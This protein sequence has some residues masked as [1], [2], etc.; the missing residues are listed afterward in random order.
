[1]E[2]KRALGHP[3]VGL[4]GLSILIATGLL[5]VAGQWYRTGDVADEWFVGLLIGAT[6]GLYQGVRWARRFLQQRSRALFSNLDNLP[7]DWNLTAETYV[8]TIFDVRRMMLSGLF[9][10][11]ACIGSGVRRF[12]EEQLNHADSNIRI[13]RW[14]DFVIGV[15]VPVQ[16]VVLLVWWLVQASEWEDAWLDPLGKTNVGTVLVQFAVVLG[17]LLLLNRFIARRNSALDSPRDAE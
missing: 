3:I 13:G 9:F 12:R 8:T 11:I 2:R 14:F 1:M 10:A 5:Y 15:L 17:L 7:P 6:V 16:A 4:F